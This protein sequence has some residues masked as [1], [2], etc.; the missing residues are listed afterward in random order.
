MFLFVCLAPAALGGP[1]APAPGNGSSTAIYMDSAA[2]IGWADAWEDYLPGDQVN[3]TFQTPEKATGK[4]NGNSFDIVSLGRAGSVTMTF[5]PPIRNGEGWDFAVFENSFS[6]TFLELAFV[7]ISSDGLNFLK[8]ESASLTS[9]PVSGFGKVDPTDIDGLGGKYR[10]GYGTPFDLQDLA[11]MPEVIAGQVNLGSIAFVRI[12]DIIGDGRSLDSSGRLIYDPYPTSNSAGFD[13]DA[14]GVRFQTGQ[15]PSVNSPE[16]P[17]LLLPA[18]E[19][20]TEIQ[21]T[22]EAGAFADP[23]ELDTHMLTKWQISNND[24]GFDPSNIIIDEI[25]GTW[26]TSLTIPAYRLDYSTTYYWRVTYY[27]TQAMASS[28]SDVFSFTTKA[29]DR[30]LDLN[31]IPDDQ[32]IDFDWDGDGVADI[33]VKSA[34]GVNSGGQQIQAGIE[35]VA[36]VASVTSMMTVPPDNTDTK[37]RPYELLSGLVAFKVQV[38]DPAEFV[39]LKIY[40]SPPAPSSALWYKY[41][42]INGWREYPHAEFAPNRTHVILTLKDG[43]ATYGDTD[44]TVDGFIIDPGGPGSPFSPTPPP[45]GES[46]LGGSGGCF[47]NATM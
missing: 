19:S 8:F 6:D 34:K 33:G 17:V 39:E 18:N 41:D 42:S 4:A 10:Q 16:K 45:D 40:L 7:E 1:Y 14:I 21:P 20:Q 15:T 29:N 38:V 11:A 2:F 32:Q 12:I 23:D 47:I 27:D 46:G 30:D 26:L 22:L 3:S 43:T 5:D 28:W 13:L 44:K 9:G 31:G 37:N 25:S 36:N 35:G 24:P